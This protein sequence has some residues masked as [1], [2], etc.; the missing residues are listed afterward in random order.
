MK[1]ILAANHRY[2]RQTESERRAGSFSFLWTRPGAARLHMW[3]V[4]EH[5]LAVIGRFPANPADAL[6]QIVVADTFEV[7]QTMTRAQINSIL[8]FAITFGGA[9]VIAGVMIAAAEMGLA[10]LVIRIYPPDMATIRSRDTFAMLF[11]MLAGLAVR[12]ARA[13][14]ERFAGNVGI[15]G[16]DK[17]W[18]HGPRRSRMS[19]PGAAILG[20]HEPQL[21]EEPT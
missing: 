12:S 6:R 11:F 16:I 2:V 13:A 15:A 20:R 9:P 7:A 18:A 5:H 4:R 17:Q 10:D 3:H 8:A 19:R 21:V 1:H 14:A